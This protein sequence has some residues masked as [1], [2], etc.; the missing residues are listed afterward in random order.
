VP[1]YIV[2]QEKFYGPLDLLLYLV[3][4]NQVDVTEIS[5]AALADQFTA[6]LTDM[7]SIELDY[8]TD[9]LRMATVLLHL[10]ARLLLPYRAEA[11]GSAADEEDPDD[12]L[13]ERLLRY[14][15][16]KLLARLL[17]ERQTGSLE[18]I[19]YRAEFMPEREAL[20]AGQPGALL[21][22]LK[23][24]LAESTELPPFMP[25][26]SDIE[27]AGKMQDTLHYLQARG[28]RLTLFDLACAL[29]RSRLEIAVLFLGLL[30]LA[31][32]QQ[33]W[34]RQDLPGSDITVHLGPAPALPGD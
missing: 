31:R 18:R 8:I 23:R 16:F 6:Y 29:G 24:A 10:K 20:W 12:Q 1:D 33:V 15:R 2:D 28:S 3:E 19:F 11:S 4:K 27:V 21:N 5:I 25:H 17:R 26:L 34:L 13:L 14:R 22:A 7:R 32:D 9:F 30:E